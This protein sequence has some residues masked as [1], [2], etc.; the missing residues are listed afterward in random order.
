[1]KTLALLLLLPVAA[2]AQDGG[3]PRAR[4]LYAE[5][6]HAESMAAWQELIAR[7]GDLPHL[8]ANLALSA[9]RA[10]ELQEA[11]SAA[12]RYA[13]VAGAELR[14]GFHQGLLGSIRFEESLAAEKAPQSPMGNPL[15]PLEQAIARAESACAHFVE[16]TGAPDAGPEARRNLERTL[17]RLAELQ[18]K[19]EEA[20]DK[21]EKQQSGKDEK[22]QPKEGEQK[23]EDQQKEPGDD[24]KGEEQQPSQPDQ[25]QDPN[26]P[27]KPQPQ[28]TEDKGQQAGEEPQQ[29]QAKPQ[30][31]ADPQQQG[32]PQPGEPK[33][34]PQRS[35]APGEQREGMELSPEERQ[36]M[37]AE[38]DRLEKLLKEYRARAARQRAGGRDW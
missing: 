9:L 17:R 7:E 36:R 21:Q 19:L 6:R 15:E 16:A 32:Q 31:Q 1:M 14:K 11:Q 20:K 29:D 2:L 34:E 30:P 38:L 18:Q 12:D 4:T 23:P 13:A 8:L 37:Y 33:P 5:G 22:Q 28:K 24:K 25:K 3:E 27:N 26:D 10:G 35:D